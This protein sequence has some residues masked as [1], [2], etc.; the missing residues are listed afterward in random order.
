MGESVEWTDPEALPREVEAVCAE[1]LALAD[2][3]VPGL[4]EG[5][6]LR[7]SLGFGEWYAGRSDVDY[8]AVLTRSP[9]A[10]VEVLASVHDRLAAA[11]PSPAFDGIHLVGEDLLAGPAATPDRPCTLQGRFLPAARKELTPVTWHELAEHAVSVRGEVPLRLWRDAQALR[12]HTRTNLA[13]YWAGQ[14]DALD[15]FRADAGI[16]D[17]A[18][19]VLGVARLHH[20]LVHGRLTSKNGAGRHVVDHFGEDWRLLA[21]EVLAW[22]VTG[23]PV[24]LLSR[25]ELVDQA[26]KFGRLVVADGSGRA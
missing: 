19:V 8:V 12:E 7:G 26:V 23:D 3:A 22:R 24:G 5:L 1:F 17:V 4:V 15:G 20:L 6:H 21:S 16:A 18:W 11:Y 13:T 14:I 2:E 9:A 10:V 25:E